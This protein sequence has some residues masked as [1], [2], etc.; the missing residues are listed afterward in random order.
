[1]SSVS[2]PSDVIGSLGRHFAIC[3]FIYLLLLV[4]SCAEGEL[5]LGVASVATYVCT[6]WVCALP[7]WEIEVMPTFSLEIHPSSSDTLNLH[8]TP[9]TNSYARVP[10]FSL[11]ARTPTYLPLGLLAGLPLAC[12]LISPLGHLDGMLLHGPRWRWWWCPNPH[13]SG[14]VNLNNLP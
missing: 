7:I 12:L 13:I 10:F 3:D 11:L 9:I 14:L 5:I 4:Q 1:M 8:P 2:A 6:P